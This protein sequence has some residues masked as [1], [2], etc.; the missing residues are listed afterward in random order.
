MKVIYLSGFSS[1]NW[2]IIF[3][4]FLIICVYSTPS[5][6]IVLDPIV[7]GANYFR[8]L[9]FFELKLVKNIIKILILMNILI[10]LL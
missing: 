2:I 5:I 9:T 1:D 7:G 4:F 6:L 8:I 3:S 10:A